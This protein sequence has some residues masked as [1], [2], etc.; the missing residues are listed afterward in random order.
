MGCASSTYQATAPSS[1]ALVPNFHFKYEIGATLGKGAF[2]QVYLATRH[3]LEEEEEE[4]EDLVTP[5]CRRRVSSCAVKV[6]NLLRSGK[7]AKGRDLRLCRLAYNEV[8]VWSLV[9]N[10]QH[11][12]CLHE[13]FFDGHLCYMVMERC[14]E[15]LICHLKKLPVVNEDT[16]AK[17]FTQMLAGI[18]HVHSVGIVHRDIKCS[19]FLIGS[20]NLVKLADFG[21]SEYVPEGGEVNGECGTVPYMC[22]EMLL[23][24]KCNLKADVWSFGVVAYLLL[25]GAFPYDA[26]YA[27]VKRAIAK[28]SPVRCTRPW[29][30][31]EATSFLEAALERDPLLRPSAA[32]VLK[33]PYIVTGSGNHQLVDLGRKLE[34]AIEANGRSRAHVSQLSPTDILIHAKEQGRIASDTRALTQAQMY[35]F[36]GANDKEKDRIVRDFWLP[37][38]CSSEKSQETDSTTCPFDSSSESASF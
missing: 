19:N 4:E 38:H 25:C 22:P 2:G 17:V 15:K 3:R 20:D 9:G 27:C 30:S 10:H 8:C 18:G 31:K 24:R 5:S 26:V 11:C 32:D 7:V 14:H 12:V 21:L 1:D 34:L 28:G 29:L 23:T 35:K 36:V 33:M 37:L 16:L 6:C 13:S